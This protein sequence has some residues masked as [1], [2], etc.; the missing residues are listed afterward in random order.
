MCVMVR[1]SPEGSHQPVVY[2][3]E[4]SKRFVEEALG[5]PISIFSTRY[6]AYSMA[7]IKGIA[8]KTRQA[9]RDERKIALTSRFR[10]LLAELLGE[11]I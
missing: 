5:I 8:E 9:N 10:S 7:G 11:F 1:G 4:T 3:D 2:V 6:E